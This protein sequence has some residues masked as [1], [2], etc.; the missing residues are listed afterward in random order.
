MF[1]SCRS[2]SSSHGTSRWPPRKERWRPSRDVSLKPLLR[3]ALRST[4]GV[5]A[6]PCSKRRFPKLPKIAARAGAPT[7]CCGSVLTSS[8]GALPSFMQ[9]QPLVVRP[10]LNHKRARKRYR[11]Y[12]KY[13]NCRAH[14]P[15]CRT[16]A[17]ARRAWPQE[18]GRKGR[19]GRN[20]K[21]PCKMGIGWRRWFRPITGRNGQKPPTALLRGVNPAH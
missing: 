18:G 15:S 1:A 6:A 19:K 4:G 5:S 20:P 3:K 14:S 16:A 9:F 7:R 12:L 17:S 2:V 21:N 13:R 8:Q 10:P 11:K